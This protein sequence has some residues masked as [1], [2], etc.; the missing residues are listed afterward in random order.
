MENKPVTTSI[1]ADMVRYM[2]Q[3]SVVQF[4][5]KRVFVASGSSYYV[6]DMK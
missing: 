3:G 5:D 4:V 1:T 6:G 2:A